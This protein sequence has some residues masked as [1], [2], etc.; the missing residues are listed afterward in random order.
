MA[1]AGRRALGPGDEHQ[2]LRAVA[3]MCGAAAS[4]RMVEANRPKAPDG[5]PIDM[6][7]VCRLLTV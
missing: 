4:R 1:R 5:Q 2:A 7:K 6:A 3:L